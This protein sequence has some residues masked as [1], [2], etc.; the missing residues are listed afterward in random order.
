MLEW[1]LH[2]EHASV[3]AEYAVKPH[4]LDAALKKMLKVLMQERTLERKRK[5]EDVP[6]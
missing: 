4:V 3:Q 2:M 6:P 5:R 1:Q